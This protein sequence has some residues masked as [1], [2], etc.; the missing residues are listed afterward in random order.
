MAIDAIKLYQQI[1]GAERA[2]EIATPPEYKFADNF[3]QQADSFQ[4]SADLP[5]SQAVNETDLLKLGD[6]LKGPSQALQ[7]KIVG[8]FLSDLNITDPVLKAAYSEQKK[9]MVKQLI[10]Q[11]TK[12]MEAHL[13]LIAKIK[14]EN[15]HE[16]EKN[17]KI[18]QLNS[19][20]IANSKAT[21]EEKSQTME[22]IETAYLQSP[23]DPIFA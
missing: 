23:D 21:T 2:A 10:D 19:S 15:A 9:A 8:I 5:F 3:A 12:S 6:L 22:K 17:T 1:A 4:S 16:K 11:F 18:T 13:A 14:A 7:E 20:E